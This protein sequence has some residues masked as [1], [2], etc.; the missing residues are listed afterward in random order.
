M[1]CHRKPR[2]YEGSFSWRWTESNL[3]TDAWLMKLF[4]LTEHVA[5]VDL[6]NEP[7]VCLIS[8][9]AK[10]SED[11]AL[12]ARLGQQLVH[13]DLLLGELELSPCLALV[14]AEPAPYT[15]THKASGKGKALQRLCPPC[16]N[17]SESSSKRYLSL[18][19]CPLWACSDCDCYQVFGLDEK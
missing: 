12:F 10:D 7:A 11:G 16:S 18:E 3:K 4:I 8:V 13:V 1:T 15:V 5:D 9:G 6:K 19:V 2:G 14:S 17:T